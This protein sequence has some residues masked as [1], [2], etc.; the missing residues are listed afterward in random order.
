MPDIS[1]GEI[2]ERAGGELSGEA[3]TRI[4]A[5]ASLDAAEPH[6]L[7]FVTNARYLP[8]LRSTRAGAVLISRSLAADPP[9]GLT[10]VRVD[11]PYAVLTWLLP[12]LYPEPP[13]VPGIHET[14][15]VAADAEIGDGV[16]IDP[17]AVVG[18]GARIGA[19]VRIGAHVVVGDGCTVG[20]DT[21]VH[22]H[23]TLSPGV[24]V[25]R[26]CVLHSGARI[27]GEGYRFVYTGG[28][29]RK[30]LHIGAC[31]LG[32]DVE[33]G[34][35]TTIDRGS[36]GDTVIGDGV[37]I[38]NLV[39]IGHNVRIGTHSLLVA[40]VGISG[41]T[42][43]GDGAILGG[44]AGVGQHLTI[45]RGA[46]VGGRAGVTGDVAPG[47]TVSG[48]PARPHREAM[49]AQAALFRLP[50]MFRKLQEIERSL[51]GRADEPPGE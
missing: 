3:G 43:V 31:R 33:V 50:A 41:G 27:G 39:Q 24:E 18:A 45:G 17:Y 46:R 7:A 35:N 4:R 23:V 21:I 51:R 32:D 37:K 10:V 48:Y 19:R 13:V 29:H 34:A 38:D 11:D 14:A 16:R 28:A 49:R 12:V 8:S 36:I 6:E 15:V 44:Q 22:P 25:G 5:V 1:V 20:D 2:A 47:E 40:Q 9:A 26:R 30:M 42:V